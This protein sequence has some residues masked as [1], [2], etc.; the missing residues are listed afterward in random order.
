M[1]RLITE[2]T[3]DGDDIACGDYD[4]MI[5]ERTWGFDE[6]IGLAPLEAAGFQVAVLK[7]TPTLLGLPVNRKRKYML[8]IKA[9]VLQWAPEIRAQGR[10]E[11]FE[12]LFQRDVVMRGDDLARASQQDIEDY[13][14]EAVA[15]RS[16]PA[17]RRSGRTLGQLETN[18]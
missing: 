16:L 12:H 6:S 13:R 10:Q 15:A 8:L 7:I 17:T 4:F 18:Q 2:Y 14:D 9:S 3:A 11:S 1:R 5:L